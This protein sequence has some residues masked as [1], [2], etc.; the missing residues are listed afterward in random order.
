MTID[1]DGAEPKRTGVTLSSCRRLTS[2]GPI[3]TV[4]G[5]EPPLHRPSIIKLALDFCSYEPYRSICSY[6]HLI[7][8]CRFAVRFRGADAE[9][10]REG[11][12]VCETPSP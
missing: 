11:W 4:L 6:G 2:N 9:K 8:A 10:Y 5:E 1:D 3:E 7:A 12:K